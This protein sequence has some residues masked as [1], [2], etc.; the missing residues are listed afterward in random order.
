MNAQEQNI[1]NMKASSS[2]I[3]RWTNTLATRGLTLTPVSLKAVELNQ[4]GKLGGNLHKYEL[5]VDITDKD[6]KAVAT[7]LYGK[8]LSKF[9]SGVQMDIH[10][11]ALKA[12][13]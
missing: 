9:I 11:E 13:K 8:K 1:F 4:V 6:G 3:E 7:G 2:K 5:V 12:T 10:R